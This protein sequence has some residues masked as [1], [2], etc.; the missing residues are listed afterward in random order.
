MEDNMKRK[1]IMRR[2]C[3][4]MKE[5][6]EQ[7]G[8]DK[9]R[10]NTGYL[11]RPYPKILFTR[12]Y[13][14]NVSLLPISIRVKKTKEEL[15]FNKTKYNRCIESRDSTVG[16]AIGYWLDDQGVGIRVQMGERIFT[17]PCRLDGL[18]G[19]HPASYSMGNTQALSAGVKLLGREA[20]PLTSS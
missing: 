20:D 9:C 16:I 19:P 2:I 17:S 7:K 14:L 13:I 3:R 15:Q 11:Y 1:R 18:W 6:E 5:N 4:R 12:P 10:L 8:E